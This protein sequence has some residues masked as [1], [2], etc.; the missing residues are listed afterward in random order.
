MPYLLIALISLF[1]TQAHTATVER[2]RLDQL[3][4]QAARV[5]VVTCIQSE[6]D[7]ID[8]AIYTRYKFTVTETVKGPAQKELELH[9][10]GG[11]F[12]GVR[13]RIAGIPTFAPGSESVLF[14]TAPN[15]L[16]HA[17]P[18][19]LAQ[20]AFR[21]ERRDD[22]AARVYQRLDGL[23]VYEGAAK[24]AN[25]S[26]SIQGAELHTFLRRVRALAGIQGYAH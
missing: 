10:P 2:F 9:L 12:Q 18:I 21:I 6:P 4:D 26:E 5:L 19:G 16:G 7:L 24:Q 8:G 22:G 20:G 15:R 3:A 11:Q 1:S 25:Q 17:W 23:T 13:S 14:L